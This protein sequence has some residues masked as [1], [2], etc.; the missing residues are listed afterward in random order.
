MLSAEVE[1][2][3]KTS[4]LSHEKKA[5]IQKLIYLRMKKSEIG[6]SM[7]PLAGDIYIKSLFNLI[8]KIFIR[9]HVSE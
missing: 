8:V 6:H 1:L 3:M 9:L 7:I 2:F 4:I 5:F